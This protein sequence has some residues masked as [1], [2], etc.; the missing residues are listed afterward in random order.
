MDAERQTGNN[1]LR[2][3]FWISDAD[4]KET[5]HSA[6]WLKVAAWL[7]RN[8]WSLTLISPG[9]AGLEVVD[10][11]S[12]YGIP[13]GNYYFLRRVMY[14]LKIAQLLL[15]RRNE[16]DIVLFHELTAPVFL[17][18]RNVMRLFSRKRPLFVMDSRS[19]LMIREDKLNFRY[20]LRGWY[21]KLMNF[22]GNRILDGRAAISEPMVESLAIPQKKLVAIW[23]SGVDL[24]LFTSI[25]GQRT[26]E[27]PMDEVWLIYTGC[28]HYERNLMNLT[29]A[30]IAV[31]QEGCRFRLTLIGDGDEVEDLKVFAASTGGQVKVFDPVAHSEIPQ[32]LLKHHIGV[33]PFPDE[34]KFN[35]SSPIKLFEYM[36]AGL[37]IYAT[38]IVC[39]TSIHHA[40]DLFFWAETSTVE[41]L[42]DGLRSIWAHRD[43]IE[44]RGRGASEA[45]Q[46]YSWDKSAEKLSDGLIRLL[47]EREAN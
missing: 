19:L 23:P 45:A 24:S 41:G 5:L 10:G 42:T 14:Q 43:Q 47:S 22:L 3:L 2:H 20:R 25:A 12:V 27:Q 33:L 13:L 15:S 26:W 40:E 36:A 39:H 6:T 4:L 44:S 46:D 21:L 28:M 17:V 35:V 31:N 1:R 7:N 32:W 34:E 37:A 11:V 30:V 8:D 16:V 38:R 29:T 9:H 18:L